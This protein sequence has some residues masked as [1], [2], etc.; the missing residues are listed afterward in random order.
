MIQYVL[1]IDGLGKADNTYYIGTWI[2]PSWDSSGLWVPEALFLWPGEVQLEADWTRGIASISGAE[3]RVVGAQAASA[4][5]P[6][7]GQLLYTQRPVSLGEITDAVTTTTGTSITTD[8]TDGSLTG[9]YLLLGREVIAFGTHGGSGVYTVTRAQRNTLGEKHPLD[10]VRKLYDA[11]YPASGHVRHR[12]IRLLKVPGDAASYTDMEALWTGVV[13]G[14]AESIP[15]TIEISAD[16]LLGM[17]AQ[18]SICRSPVRFKG[19][20]NR[21]GITYYVSGSSGR[22]PVADSGALYLSTGDTVVGQVTYTENAAGSRVLGQFQVS[23]RSALGEDKKEVWEVARTEGTSTYNA[24]PLNK[25]IFYRIIQHLTT[26]PGGGNGSYDVT[27]NSP[28]A[29]VY[30]VGIPASLVDAARFAALAR[31][32]GEVAEQDHYLS[33]DGKPVKLGDHIASLLAPYGCCLVERGGK[34]SVA[35]FADVPQINPTTLVEADFYEAPTQVRVLDW[36]LDEIVASWNGAPGQEPTVDT[37][38]EG[39]A[40]R[41]NVYG[42]PG[43][44]DLDLTGI[45]IRARV[46]ALAGLILQR[47]ANAPN[48]IGAR[49]LRSAAESIQVGDVIPV[50][51][52]LLRTALGARGAVGARCLVES[53]R[54]DRE[55]GD[56]SLELIDLSNIYTGTA[57]VIAPSG[58]VGG[59]DNGTKTITLLSGSSGFAS[60][61]VYATDADSF[62]P[63]V[64]AKISICSRRHVEAG[65]ATVVSTGVNSIV[66]S[67]ET[68]TPTAGQLIKV[69][70]YDEGGNTDATKLLYAWLADSS[71]EVDGDATLV[72]EWTMV[73]LE[74]SV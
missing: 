65:T 68:T 33:V 58:I 53:T 67:G 46:A 73:A 63:C 56:V 32:F 28:G 7:L 60:G 61:D 71:G 43:N 9:T 3:F 21:T 45:R 69:V 1:T 39:R 26:T 42:G 5:D 52:P 10:E 72:A 66:V 23:G 20:A 47:R 19:G 59:W 17:L 27:T 8:V 48:R 64:G 70:E 36:G 54:K 55:K 2:A 16:G 49:L 74:E 31:L 50:T 57:R 34:I 18:V 25:N 38:T 37:F 41:L 12:R 6:K 14:I 44:I 62:A 4:S 29:G 51:H 13:Q 11:D 22:V 30:G 40:A 15:G 24:L 35:L